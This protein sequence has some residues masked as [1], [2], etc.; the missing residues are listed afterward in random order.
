MIQAVTRWRAL[1]QRIAHL[2]G[3]IGFTPVP[4]SVKPIDASGLAGRV[5]TF[6][7]SDY[8]YGVGSL[9]LRVDRVNA[10][11]PVMEAGE[12]WYWVDGVQVSNSGE[13]LRP[14]VVLVRGRRLTE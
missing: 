6:P 7:E 8:Q 2:F 12:C 5:V 4:R 13:D 11:R 9:R 1:L 3:D 14:R 10:V